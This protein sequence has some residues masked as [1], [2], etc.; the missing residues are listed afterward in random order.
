MEEVDREQ[1]RVKL[2]EGRN[3]LPKGVLNPMHIT[4]MESC[5]SGQ[6]EISGQMDM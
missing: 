1:S 4:T 3:C 5:G 2:E 6:G